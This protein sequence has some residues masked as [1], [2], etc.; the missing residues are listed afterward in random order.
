MNWGARGAHVFVFVFFQINTWHLGA[1]FARLLMTNWKRKREEGDGERMHGGGGGQMEWSG[2]SS[3]GP[4]T[5]VT[6]KLPSR[7]GD[8]Q[9]SAPSEWVCMT[10]MA[11][12]RGW[13]AR[14]YMLS[15]R[16]LFFWRYLQDRGKLEKKKKT[17]GALG[18]IKSNTGDVVGGWFFVF[19]FFCFLES[20]KYPDEHLP[21]V[22]PVITST[23]KA[24]RAPLLS[25]RFRSKLQWYC[26]SNGIRNIPLNARTNCFVTILARSDPL[27]MHF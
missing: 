14:I 23:F 12:I 27:V 10:T 20:D 21:K 26:G 2:R 25:F 24:A 5:S 6:V 8:S 7:P 11:P 3:V 13:V 4:L 1:P 19:C 22:Q 17:E 16:R 15:A 18:R 9:V